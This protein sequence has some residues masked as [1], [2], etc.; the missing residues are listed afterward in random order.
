MHTSPLGRPNAAVQSDYL[1]R[2]SWP[3]DTS[4]KVAEELRTAKLHSLPNFFC[5]LLW[6]ATYLH[7]V[8]LLSSIRCLMEF[9]LKIATTQTNAWWQIVS[10]LHSGEMTSLENVTH[11][12]SKSNLRSCDCWMVTFLYISCILTNTHTHTT[13]TYIHIHT[14][15]HTTHTHTKHHWNT[16]AVG[17][18]TYSTFQWAA[19]LTW[20]HSSLYTSMKLSRKT[21]H[22]C[23]SSPSTA[24]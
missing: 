8:V 15:T 14:H 22:V 5:V 12:R 18:H 16:C 4:V 7:R 2:S 13:H 9:S 17:T 24:S 1:A 3:P 20:A 11:C 10:T 6:L 23:T 19:W 21:H